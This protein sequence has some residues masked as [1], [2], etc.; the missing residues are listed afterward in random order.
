MSKIMDIARFRKYLSYFVLFRLYSAASEFSWNKITDVNQI[1]DWDFRV[2]V[3]STSKFQ[4]RFDLG[5][6]PVFRRSFMVGEQGR[7][8][9]LILARSV[10]DT[11]VD[12]D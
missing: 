10:H 12:L 9:I 4:L 1:I 6:W 5:Y 8:E 2:D 11:G 7:I 3:A